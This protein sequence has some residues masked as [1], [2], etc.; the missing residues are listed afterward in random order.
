MSIHTPSWA[1]AIL[2]HLLGKPSIPISL[3]TT[4]PPLSQ[5]F[6]QQDPTKHWHLKKNEIHS[7]LS[8]NRTRALRTHLKQTN[9]SGNDERWRLCIQSTF[10]QGETDSLLE[11]PKSHR[12]GDPITWWEDRIVDYIL[13]S[14]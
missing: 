3:F 1:N 7:Y 4:H 10:T 13:S 12:N 5:Q 2:F 6:L 14:Q 8:P 11:L 9:C